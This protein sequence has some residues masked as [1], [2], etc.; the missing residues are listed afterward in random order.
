MSAA[1][2]DGLHLELRNAPDFG[3]GRAGIATV[4]ATA[5]ALETMTG[6]TGSPCQVLT[7]NVRASV[8]SVPC[9]RQML[10]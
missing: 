9:G 2:K 5:S 6:A 7:P 4:I 8:G 3:D 1:T 10:S